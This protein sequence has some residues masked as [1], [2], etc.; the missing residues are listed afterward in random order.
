MA[1]EFLMLAEAKDGML[2]VEFLG[3]TATYSS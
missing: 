2:T 3:S 1:S